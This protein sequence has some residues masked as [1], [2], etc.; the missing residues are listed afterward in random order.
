MKEK[1]VGIIVEGSR[2]KEI[3]IGVV[4]EASVAEKIGCMEVVMAMMVVTSIPAFPETKSLLFQSFEFC[5]L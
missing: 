3:V 1:I 2:A 5:N 4:V